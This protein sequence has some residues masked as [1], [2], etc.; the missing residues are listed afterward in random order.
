MFFHEGNQIIHV[1]V[2]N[3]VRLVGVLPLAGRTG[4]KGFAGIKIFPQLQFLPD[5]FHVY[6]DL[7]CFFHDLNEGFKNV[8]FKLAGLTAS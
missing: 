4:Q 1:Y 7:D 5:L 3:Q 6:L 8:P 2:L